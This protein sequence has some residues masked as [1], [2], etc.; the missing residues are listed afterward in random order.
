ML[1]HLRGKNPEHREARL[2]CLVVAQLI[3]WQDQHWDQLCLNCRDT[4][5]HFL[6]RSLLGLPTVWSPEHRPPPPPSSLPRPHWL[7]PIPS[8]A[9]WALYLLLACPDLAGRLELC[10]ALPRPLNKVGPR[11][12][13]TPQWVLPN[14]TAPTQVQALCR[15]SGT[16]NRSEPVPEHKPVYKGMEQ[17]QGS[18]IRDQELSSHPGD[19]LLKASLP[20]EGVW[21]VRQGRP[22]GPRATPRG[23]LFPSLTF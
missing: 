8:S 3:H 5:P 6:L 16:A 1:P 14:A 17:A 19:A 21:W 7:L 13:S 2:T 11:A 15:V 23:P 4:A 22:P 18:L 12:L 10:C 20:L 9:L